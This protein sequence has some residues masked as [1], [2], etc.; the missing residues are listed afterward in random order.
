MA[1]LGL[2]MG[3][4]QAVAQSQ[5]PMQTPS[6]TQG[7]IPA[8]MITNLSTR[9]TQA[10]APGQWGGGYGTPMA[11]APGITFVIL[12]CYNLTGTQQ[13]GRNMIVQGSVQN[14]AQLLRVSLKFNNNCPAGKVVP[15]MVTIPINPAQ[16]S[17]LPVV[18]LNPILTN[19]NVMALIG[20]MGN[21]GGG[22]SGHYT[23]GG[24]SAPGTF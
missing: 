14:G 13:N 22:Y 5:T 21:F 11:Q 19:V 18:V 2:L 23:G 8:I 17:N 20:G 9:V 24:Y 15:Q 12:S 10:P 7:A 3:A 6:Q 16:F 4:N 1:V